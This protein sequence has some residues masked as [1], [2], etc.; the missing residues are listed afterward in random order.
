[1]SVASVEHNSRAVY[2]ALL[3]TFED[4]RGL[5][6]ESLQYWFDHFGQPGSFRATQFIDGLMQHVGMT[7]VQRRSLSVAL[8]SALGQ[9]TQALPSVPDSLRP[10]AA[11]DRMVSAAL[12][13]NG[14]GAPRSAGLGRSAAATPAA[15]MRAAPARAASAVVFS[16]VVGQIVEELRRRSG[17][18]AEFTEAL[19]DTADSTDLPNNLRDALV[20]WVQSH[21]SEDACPD[22][23]PV[24]GLRQC[25]N[26][27][28]IA[29]CEV[30]GPVA[31]DRVLSK[32]IH[33]AEE[34]PEAAS[35]APKQLL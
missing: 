23:F 19:I 2:S 34:L 31:T 32:A 20:T 28:Y 3:R 5:L 29:M 12:A 16:R 4:N 24:G 27:I 35:F 22:E 13:G 25:L 21:F 9:P 15:L 10:G 8:Y 26:A 6:R 18:L 11:A 30:L 14:A 7:D 17:A 1:M 33:A